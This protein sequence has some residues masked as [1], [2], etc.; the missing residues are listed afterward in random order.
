MEFNKKYFLSPSSISLIKQCKR[1]FWLSQNTSWRRPAQIFSSLPNGIDKILKKHFDNF[2][3][4]KKLP[5]VLQETGVCSNCILLPD[6]D[7]I[8]KWRDTRQ[9]IRYQDIEGNIFI[10]AVDEVLIK[11][12]KLIVLDYK[13]R[14]FELKENTHLF[15]KDQLNSYSFL[16]NKQGYDIEDYGLLVFYI[17]QAVNFEGDVLFDTEIVKI[18]VSINEGLRLFQDAINFLKQPCPPKSQGCEWCSHIGCDF[19]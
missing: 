13:T 16:L 14:G 7:K 1:C 3:R 17:P 4:I 6:Q 11:E 18:P 15:Y 12:N 8:N 9:G 5:P 19:I 10:G 2:R